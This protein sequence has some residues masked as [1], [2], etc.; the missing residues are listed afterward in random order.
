MFE[1][2]AGCFVGSYDV[3]V[4]SRLLLRACLPCQFTRFIYNLY[5]ISHHSTSDD[6]Y[7]YRPRSEVEDRKRVDNPIAR[8]NLFLKSRGWWS[9]EEDEELRTRLKK[10]VLDG[11]RKAEAAKANRLGVL[12]TDVYGG[13]E[14]FNIVCSL[15][16]FFSVLVFIKGF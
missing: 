14:P 16:F 15:K 1:E 3:S 8:F 12:F 10:E 11:F 4:G 2:W 13:E 5:S 6:S 9:D 7:A